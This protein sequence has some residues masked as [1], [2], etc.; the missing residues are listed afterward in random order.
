MHIGIQTYTTIVVRQPYY[1]NVISP[2]TW[3]PIFKKKYD[4]KVLS[5]EVIQF[6]RIQ[7]TLHVVI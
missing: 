1:V 2:Y 6:K 4:V 5:A 3:Y 7:K